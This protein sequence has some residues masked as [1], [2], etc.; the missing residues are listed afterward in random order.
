M[1]EPISLFKEQEPDK[2]RPEEPRPTKN[3]IYLVTLAVG[4]TVIELFRR[5]GRI[6]LGM[7]VAVCLA[8]CIIAIWIRWDL[9]RRLWFWV[10]VA[11]L[12]AL[13]VPLFFLIKWPHRWVPGV[14]LLPIGIADLLLFL[15]AVQFVED[16]IV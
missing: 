8:M 4:F 15:G 14:A 10:V 2:D 9:R 6:D 12:L 13:H 16:F 11:L 1:D 5:F 3:H 7:N